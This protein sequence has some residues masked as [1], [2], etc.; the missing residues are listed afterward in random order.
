MGSI[1]DR[2]HTACNMRSRISLFIDRI[3]SLSMR[4]TN[5]KSIEQI[6]FKSKVP[7]LANMLL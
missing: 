1:F 7:S 3:V 5:I 6:N 2:T 4:S